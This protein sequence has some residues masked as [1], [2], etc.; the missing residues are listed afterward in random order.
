[1]RILA[2]E[3]NPADREILH[4]LLEDIQGPA[5]DIE[6]AGTVSEVKSLISGGGFDFIIL[7][8]G[9]PDSQ[10][11]DTLKAVRSLT[12]AT[13]IIVLTGLDDEET[14]LKAFH[15]GAQDYL[16]KGQITGPSLVRSIRYAKER[17]HIEQELIRKN[18]ELD[19]MN[20]ELITTEEEL[21]RNI[22][23]LKLR[24]ED[25]EKNQEKLSEALDEK[26]VLLSEIHHRVKN[27]LAAFISLLSLEGSYDNSPAGI[28]MKKDLQNRARS[29]ALIHETLYRTRNYSRVDLDMYLSTLVEQTINS[30]SA[31]KSFRSSVDVH[32][33]TLDI[34]R[35]TPVG[36]IVNE[37]VT[38]S[39]KYAFPA[40]FNCS[41]ERN[42][43]G[44]IWISLTKEDKTYVLVVGD[45][46]IGLPEEIDVKS[47]RSLGL[48][49]VYFLSKHQLKANLEIERQMGTRYTFRFP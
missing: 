30:Y 7:D 20:E 11:I 4:E 5:Y 10:G 24:E 15:E 23:E 8:L 35:A 14:G 39:L 45:N 49:L 25:L 48:K 19:V 42:E 26:E 21:R 47:S 36:L 27:N 12:S 29:M 37:L 34:M 13:P 9:L 44:R 33:I 6:N 1:M 2:I 43:P 16:I 32:G 17:N 41:K 40:S 28:A 18:A 38:N 31:P 46:G 3:D 22:N